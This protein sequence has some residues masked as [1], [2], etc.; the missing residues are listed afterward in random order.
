ME[1]GGSH[2]IAG[3]VIV[4]TPPFEAIFH[5]ANDR[6]YTEWQVGRRLR[7]GAWTLCLRQRGPDRLLVEIEDGALLLLAPIEPR[8]LPAGIEVRV[9]GSHARIVDRRDT[10]PA[11]GSTVSRADTA[12]T[13]PASSGG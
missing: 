3:G 12:R 9:S 13:E 7:T 8:Q 6:Y 11:A 5:G 4:V 2:R 10:S 1:T